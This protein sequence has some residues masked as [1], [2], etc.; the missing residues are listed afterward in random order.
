MAVFA[1]QW[2]VHLGLFRETLRRP[3]VGFEDTDC[4]QMNIDAP[5]A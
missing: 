3:S 1:A 2:G 4:A 5:A